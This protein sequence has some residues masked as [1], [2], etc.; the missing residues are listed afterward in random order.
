MTARP[1]KIDTAREIALRR[2]LYGP[3][4]RR[5]RSRAEIVREAQDAARALA[6]ATA[7]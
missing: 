1:A 4:A 6:I 5:T 2:E 7:S 3:D